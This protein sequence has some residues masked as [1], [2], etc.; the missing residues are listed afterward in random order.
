MPLTPGTKE[1][2]LGAFLEC[3]IYGFYLSSFMECC[4][5]FCRKE[6]RRDVKQTYVIFT[7]VVMFIFITVRCVID[8]YRCVA[9]FDIT[10]PSG[11]FGLGDPNTTLD[12]VTNAFWFFLTPFADAF[13]IF[14]TFHVWNRNWF[15][16]IL[17][18]LLCVANLGSS[19]WLMVALANLETGLGPTVWANIVFTSLNLFL[20]LTLCTN[21]VCTG[22]ISFRIM[23]LHRQITHM[24]PNIAPTYTVRAISIIVE[25]AA[26]YTLV[27][28]GALA[29]NRANSFVNFVFFDCTPPTIGLVFSYI[30]I[31]VS[32]GTA[33]EEQPT[34]ATL[35][36]QASVRFRSGNN[37]GVNTQ[38]YELDRNPG[39]QVR[40]DRETET[41]VTRLSSNY[42][43]KQ[44]DTMV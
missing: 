29:S 39:V 6:R 16:I 12:L 17:P 23:S 41:D 2:Y 24:S 37:T 44:A 31:R 4:V 34:N 43:V 38:A 8:I 26:I 19:I 33:Y 9:A 32:R 40:L 13:I 18:V 21:I 28:V 25:S 10:D 36:S 20:S 14:R 42:G 27:L 30:I 11:D 1:S 7:A 5:L 22:L 15:V 3:I 35:V